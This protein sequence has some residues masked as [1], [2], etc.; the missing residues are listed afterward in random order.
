MRC[1]CNHFSNDLASTLVGCR[2]PAYVNR[3]ANLGKGLLR[4]LSLPS[5][6]LGGFLAGIKQV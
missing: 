3:T 4:V 6:A 5:Q 1:N 2:I